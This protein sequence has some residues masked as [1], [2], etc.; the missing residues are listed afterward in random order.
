MTTTPALAGTDR[1][2]AYGPQIA[3]YFHIER[4]PMLRTTSFRDDQLAVTR[5][6]SASREPGMSETIPPEDS[7]LCEL[8]LADLAHHELWSRGRRVSSRSYDKGSIRIV[9]LRDEL[10]AY[11]GSPL[12]ALSFYLPRS[13]IDEF[14]DD[15]GAARIARLACEPGVHDP[16]LAHL[17]AALLPVLE[18]PQLA[19][20][21]FVEHMALAISAH[22]LK[23]YGGL[24]TPA[25]REAGALSPSREKRAKEFLAA[26]VGADVSVAAAAQACG[27]SRAYFIRAFRLSTGLTPHKWLQAYRI[28]KVK[29][30]LMAS[31]DSIVDIALACGFADQSHLTRAFAQAVGMPPAAWRRQRQH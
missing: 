30:A 2:G 22:V 6:E 14:S 17:G 25:S 31:S 4:A 3:R 26:S 1:C 9:D 12:D 24:A 5:L 8:Q 21:L 11:V 10:C 28:D 13:A 16:L 20:R 7:F 19:S 18:Q 29:Q 15:I 23:R 27:L